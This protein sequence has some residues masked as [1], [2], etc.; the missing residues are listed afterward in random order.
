MSPC[1][2]CSALSK[3]ESGHDRGWQ[4]EWTNKVCPKCGKP[5][6][7]SDH[8]WVDEEN[9]VYHYDCFKGETASESQA[10]AA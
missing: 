6:S 9:V 4:E 3:D 8:L 1:M 7:S 2:S 10:T 5:F